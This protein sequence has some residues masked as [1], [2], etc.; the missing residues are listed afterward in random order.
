MSGLK[1]LV[2]AG[3]AGLLFAAT[4]SRAMA[5]ISVSVGAAPDCPFWRAANTFNVT[6]FSQ[7]FAFLSQ[8]SAPAESCFSA[9]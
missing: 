9:C 3:A 2:L 1:I 8:V 6:D 4:P 5:Q 7:A